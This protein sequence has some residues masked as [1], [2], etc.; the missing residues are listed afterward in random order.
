[1]IWGYPYFWK[2]QYTH[3]FLFEYARPTHQFPSNLLPI[4]FPNPF[5][6]CLGA[7]QSV[8][9]C[10]V[11]GFLWRSSHLCVAPFVL[12]EFTPLD[13]VGSLSRCLFIIEISKVCWNEVRVWSLM[14]VAHVLGSMISRKNRDETPAR[15]FRKGSCTS[16]QFHRENGVK[17][18][19]KWGALNPINPIIHLK[20]RGVF[21]G[22]QSPFKG[23]LGGVL[24]S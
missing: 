11:L 5:F 19:F 3:M 22:S 7:N 9:P 14:F 15:L 18:P 21:I 8:K 23:L 16:T 2:H 4:R 24:N 20:S 6:H 13:F 12:L 1:M 17:P 10:I